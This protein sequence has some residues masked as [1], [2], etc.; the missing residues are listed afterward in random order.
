MRQDHWSK[1]D[2]FFFPDSPR[3]KVEIV[4]LVQVFRDVVRGHE[5]SVAQKLSSSLCP[6]CHFDWPVS[7]LAHW[8][9]H[10]SSSELKHHLIITQ[11]RNARNF[12]AAPTPSD[13]RAKGSAR[14]GAYV[15]MAT[16]VGIG[17]YFYINTSA[18]G[19]KPL[20]IQ[21]KSPLDP[22]EWINFPL[23]RVEPYNHNT[24]K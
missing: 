5:V 8:Q 9:V 12:A 21:E 22:K 1:W 3:S 10:P 17:T 15:S 7:C 6:P 11:T 20:K 19:V 24:S 14:I 23:K 18:A 2:H 13:E 4:E 16:L